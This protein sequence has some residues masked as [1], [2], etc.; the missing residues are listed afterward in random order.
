MQ[1]L[2]GEG[3][4]FRVDRPRDQTA[5]LVFDSPHSGTVY[6]VDFEVLVPHAQLRQAEDMYIDELFAGVTA[7][8]SPLLSALFPRSYIDPNRGLH[9]FDPAVIDGIWPGPVEESKKTDLGLGLI[10]RKCRPDDDL[11]D[12]KLSIAEAQARIDKYWQPYHSALKTLLDETREK[13][14]VVWHL[15]CHSMPEIAG[16]LSNEDPGNRRPEICLGDRHGTTCSPRF[17]EL[18]RTIFADLGYEVTVNDPYAGVE[19]VRAYSD[20]LQN[21]HSL[22]IEI[23]RDL[24]MDEENF[25]KTEKFP[26]IV[27]DLELLAHHLSQETRQ[28]LPG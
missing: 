14:G 9:E 1:A 12:R 15:D 20:P 10:W 23:R 4:A 13:F 27:R 25:E 2:P 16:V 28:W 11:Y 22:Q 3:S 19:L 8:G 6:P 17:T 5:P 7:Q 24:Y 21:R 18:V 26:K